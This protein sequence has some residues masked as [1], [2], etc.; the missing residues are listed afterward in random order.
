MNAIQTAGLGKRFHRTWALRDCTLAIPAGHVVALVGPN[1][2]GKTTMLHMAVGLTTPT[3]GAVTVLGG[4]PAGSPD[5]LD[6]IAFV[7]QDAPLL[8]AFAIGAF[9]GAAIRRT[10]PAMA[11]SLAAWTGLDLATV[12][13]LR[14]HYEA[15]VIARGGQ[16]RFREQLGGEQLVHGTE[17]PAGEPVSTQ[18]RDDEG[19]GVG[20]EFEGPGHLRD[21]A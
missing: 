14:K 17:R 15:P 12:L 16:P 2:A 7:A 9:A 8:A 19:P 10:V 4:E 3:T 21:V 5:A 13:F 18:R 6:R 20:P 1:G 11:A